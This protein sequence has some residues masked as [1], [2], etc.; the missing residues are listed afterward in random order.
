IVLSAIVVPLVLISYLRGLNGE[1]E[2]HKKIVKF[3]YP[4]WL[5][6]TLTGVVVYLMI[7]P[8]YAFNQ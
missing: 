1:I 3:A 7:S 5:Y 6:V 2:R 4:I 8:Y